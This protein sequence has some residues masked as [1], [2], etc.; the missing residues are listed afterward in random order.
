[1]SR[2]KVLFV[3][4][5]LNPYT[6]IS[7]ISDIARRIPHFAANDYEFR[8]LMPKFGI[9]NERRHRLHEVVRLSGMNII[10]D[11]EDY[12]L[13]I[14]VASLPGARLQVYFL[15]NEEF[16]KR[17][18]V[19][20]DEDNATFADNQERF[21]KFGWSPD[22]V[23]LHGQITSLIPL[24]MKKAYRNDPVFSNA[25]IIYTMYDQDLSPSFDLKFLN[26]AA[27]NDL[28]SED[29]VDFREGDMINLNLGAIKN[30]DAI[31]A[32]SESAN[33]LVIQYGQENKLPFQ[34]SSSEVD[35]TAQLSVN[36]YNTLLEDQEK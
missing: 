21:K 4:Q 10:V 5:E 7:I 22:I 9:I 11:D 35:E 6:E 28:E 8:I 31:I 26:L 16:F 36:F 29:L 30:A 32:G 33:D 18:S 24:Y 27:I 14:K 1:M 23:H 34:T 15:D 13:I 20:E 19:F 3:T 17:K 25:K 12:P 2:K